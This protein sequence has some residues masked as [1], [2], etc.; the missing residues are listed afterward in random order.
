[1]DFNKDK[2]YV[3]KTQHKITKTYSI[4]SYTCDHKKGYIQLNGALSKLTSLAK[5]RNVHSKSLQR[6][7]T[8]AYWTNEMIKLFYFIY[9]CSEKPIKDNQIKVLIQREKSKLI[10]F[11]YSLWEC[12]QLCA[13]ETQ[14]KISW[15]D[16]SGSRD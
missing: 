8:S 14:E 6:K 9:Y 2:I 16:T 1:M 15:D 7:N 10:K 4:Y 3:K 13:S 5:E 11:A 12:W